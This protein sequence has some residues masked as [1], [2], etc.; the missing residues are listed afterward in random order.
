MTILVAVRTGAAVVLAADSKLTTQAPGGKNAAGDLIWLLQ[1]YDHAVKIA[2]DATGTA[3]AAFAGNGNIG[4]QNAADYFSRVC[5]HLNRP[6][7][8]QDV[9][10]K[11]I[12]EEMVAARAATVS[13]LG[14]KAVELSSTTV[15]LASAPTPGVAPR[16]WRIDLM[17]GGHQTAE[18]LT[19]AG[20]WFEGSSDAMLGLMYGI[21]PAF[22]RAIEASPGIDG[23]A[24][25]T[26]KQDSR[27]TCPIRQINFWTMPLQDAMDFASFA[28]TVQVEIERFRPG[29]PACGGPI[30][31]MVLEMAPAPRIRHFPG[32]T[33]H[34]PIVG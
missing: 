17:D 19:G 15:L 20:V 8:E 7:A 18:I 27:F 21:L 4:D 30:D 22:D 5:A 11:E 25:E 13:T 26:A 23:T 29:T 31:I 6:A 9:R 12:V 34:H 10:L 3:V 28:A 16:V 2:Q 1:T 33:L 24:F 32:K 14:I